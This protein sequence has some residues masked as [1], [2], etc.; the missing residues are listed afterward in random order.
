MFDG[1]H[2]KKKKKIKRKTE[3]IKSPR[4][5][6]NLLRESVEEFMCV[7]VWQRKSIK[8]TRGCVLACV[9]LF[10]SNVFYSSPNLP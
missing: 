1:N 9:F 3:T 4:N 2:Q 7:Q 5:H 6:L 10:A 8:K